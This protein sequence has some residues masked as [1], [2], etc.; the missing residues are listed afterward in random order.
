MSLR[1]RLTLL[2]STLLGSVLLLF[3]GLIYGLASVA[4]MTKIDQTLTTTAD[5]LVNV[6]KI[7]SS[8][9]FDPRSIA[10]FEVSENLLIQV[11]G[12]DQRLQISRPTG[13]KTPLDVSNRFKGEASLASVTTEGQHLRVLTVPLESVRSPAGVMQ[14]G[15]NLSLL[16]LLEDTLST[17]L[18]VLT[19]AGMLV[20]SLFTWLMTSTVLEPLS[21]MTHVVTQITRSGDLSRRIPVKNKRSDNEINKLVTAFNQ[22]LERLENLFT[23]QQ[24]FLGDVS[25]ELR[26]PLTV[27]KGNIGLMRKLGEADEESLSS[28]ESEV[29][30]LTRLVGDLLLINQAESGTLPLDLSPVELDGL[31]FEVFQ[32]MHVIAGEKINLKLLEIDQ[33]K[34]NADRD[35]IKQVFLNLIGNAIQY[36]PAGGTV[37]I[38]MKREE[39]CAMVSISDSGPG[40]PAEDLPRIFERF[41]RGEKSRKRSHSTGFGLGLS[42]AQIIVKK[43]EGTIDVTSV[44]GKGTTFTVR[45]PLLKEQ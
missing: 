45:F 37:E 23:S 25:H 31:L 30:R 20:S 18:V 21:T 15:I 33:A 6:L 39:E 8:G 4:L 35:R 40:I 5:Q 26:T 43:H 3:G 13:W 28:I 36:T 32:Q 19:L 44:E 24:H 14:I 42:I 10:G 29:D 2:Y 34:I 12:N 9:I 1:L 22:T 17:I 11:W 27:I 16:D 38:R 7:D 41:Y